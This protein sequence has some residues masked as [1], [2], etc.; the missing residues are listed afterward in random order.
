MS[1]DSARSKDESYCARC[2]R[3]V[4]PA[5]QCPHC[6][7]PVTKRLSVRFFRIMALLVG[8]VGLGLL[9]LMS[10]RHELPL[11]RIA[12]IQRTMNF[13]FVRVQGTVTSDARLFSEGGQIASVA[14]TINDGSEELDVRAY[15][16]KAREL[17]EAD[18]LPRSGDRVTVGGSLQVSAD[19]MAMWIADKSL[20]HIERAEIRPL[21]LMDLTRDLESRNVIIQGIITAVDTPKAGTRAPWT[22]RWTDGTGDGRMTLWNDLYMDLPD[23]LQLAPNTVFRAMATVVFQQERLQF[24]LNRIA[25]L[26][27]LDEA[28]AKV[29]ATLET[30]AEWPEGDLG[31]MVRAEGRI[32][33]LTIPPEG[34]RAMHR[35]KIQTTT[36]PLEIVYVSAS[37]HPIDRADFPINESITVRGIREQTGQGPRLRIYHPAQLQP[38]KPTP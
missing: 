20:I 8:V 5:N 3:F 14:F 13:A 21:R 6:G 32:V 28:P 16:A 33:S 38:S 31:Q 9:Y 27:F 2:G 30:D 26:T 36:G 18:L 29:A 1:N 11:I 7:A 10:T 4:G 24:Q 22:V 37:G 17:V 35:I 12:D 25:D 19:S 34:S 15:R 23:K